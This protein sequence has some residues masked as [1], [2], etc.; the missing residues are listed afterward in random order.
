MGPVVY[1]GTTKLFVGALGMGLAFA[2]ARRSTPT[3]RTMPRVWGISALTD[4]AIAGLIMAVEQSIVMGVAL[5]MLF[6]L[7]LSESEREQQRRER[8]EAA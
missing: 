6:M 1:M 3:T 7:A 5:V 2:P 4:Q 8:Y